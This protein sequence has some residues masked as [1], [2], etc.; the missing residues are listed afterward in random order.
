MSPITNPATDGLNELM[1]K[2]QVLLCLSTS[3]T[4][5]L[6]EQNCSNLV[7]RIQAGKVVKVGLQ[8]AHNTVSSA[9]SIPRYSLPVPFS[10]IQMDCHP[11]LAITLLL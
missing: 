2:N 4:C 3:F 5:P 6:L 9:A 11:G 7:G 8:H 10:K 1:L